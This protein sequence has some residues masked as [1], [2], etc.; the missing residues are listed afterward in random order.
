MWLPQMAPLYNMSICHSFGCLKETPSGSGER[1][2]RTKM[3][4]WAS[5]WQFWARAVLQ[6]GWEFRERFSLYLGVASFPPKWN[7]HEPWK[8]LSL[9][10]GAASEYKGYWQD[11]IFHTALYFHKLSA[12][13]PP[14]WTITCS[15]ILQLMQICNS[16]IPIGGLIT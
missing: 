6:W 13:M 11:H 1:I 10:M 14:F 16:L 8:S 12:A 7:E 5:D 15:L 4:T 3:T 9:K 2:S